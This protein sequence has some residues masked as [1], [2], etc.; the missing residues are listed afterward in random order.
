MSTKP[1]KQDIKD[2]FD[3]K[4]NLEGNSHK[5][6]FNNSRKNSKENLKKKRN[7]NNSKNKNLL[8]IIIPFYKKLQKSKSP[9]KI[10]QGLFLELNLLIFF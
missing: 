10:H 2:S 9:E 8:K 4:I 7:S 1:E 5:E 3:G 6:I